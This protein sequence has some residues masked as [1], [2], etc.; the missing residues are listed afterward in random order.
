MWQ[1]INDLVQ[2][3]YFISYS[4][5][6]EAFASSLRA[7]LGD[8]SSD[9]WQDI[10]SIGVGDD[11]REQIRIGVANCDELILLLSNSSISSEIVF[12]EVTIAQSLGKQI[13]PFVIN[14]LPGILPEYLG[15]FNYQSVVHQSPSDALATIAKSLSSSNNDWKLSVTRNIFPVFSEDAIRQSGSTNSFHAIAPPMLARA[16]T[17]HYSS[18]IW[19][20]LG[21]VDCVLGQWKSGLSKLGKYASASRCFPGYYML[22]LHKLEQ[23][24]IGDLD[25]SIVDELSKD[26]DN[27][28]QL[29]DHPLAILLKALIDREGRNLSHERLKG[30]ISHSLRLLSLKTEDVGELLRFIWATGNNLDALGPFKAQFLNYVRGQRNEQYS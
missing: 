20:N 15:K 24:R 14:R 30:Q 11:W 6:D 19:L 22:A 3:R 10:D 23:N 29:Q 4:R 25:P 7:M 1:S 16:K 8:Q 9:V 17:Y 26:L 13:R 21:L 27:A 18:A 2:P 5:K 12:E 28:L